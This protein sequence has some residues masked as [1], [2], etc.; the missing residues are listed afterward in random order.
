MFE[1]Y[2]KYPKDVGMY[3]RIYTSVVKKSHI[4]K[5]GGERNREGLS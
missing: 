2:T 1:T 3:Y 5:Q 4:Q